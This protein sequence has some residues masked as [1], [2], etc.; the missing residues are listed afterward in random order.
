LSDISKEKADET[1]QPD[2]APD[3]LENGKRVAVHGAG[4]DGRGR[5]KSS[6]HEVEPIVGVGV[7]VETHAAQTGSEV[8][9]NVGQNHEE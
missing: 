9:Q 3:P 6:T 5:G 2:H 4:D 8:Q 7:L 1:D